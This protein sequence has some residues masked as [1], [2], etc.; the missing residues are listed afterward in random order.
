MT[1]LKAMRDTVAAGFV[2]LCDWGYI[3]HL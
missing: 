3:C 2:E 1:Y